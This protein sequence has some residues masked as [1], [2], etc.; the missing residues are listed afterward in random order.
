MERLPEEDTWPIIT[1]RIEYFSPKQTAFFV[2]LCSIRA[3]PFIGLSGNF[4]FWGKDKINRHLYDVLNTIDLVAIYS[5]N[6]AKATKAVY[7][8][9]ATKAANAAYTAKA[10]YAADAAVQSL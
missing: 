3:L 5:D 6:I 7:A 9:K 8:A 10:A 4:N 2:W 1:G